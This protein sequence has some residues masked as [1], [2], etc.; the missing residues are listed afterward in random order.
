[1]PLDC[2]DTPDQPPA[3]SRP[4]IGILFECCGIYARLYR[5]PDRMVYQ[6]RCPKCLRSVRVRVGRDGVNSR[7]FRAC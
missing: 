5:R 6:G 3:E 4:Y 2:Y 1:V 7:L